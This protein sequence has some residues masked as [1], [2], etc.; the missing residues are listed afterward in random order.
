MYIKNVGIG[1][2]AGVLLALGFPSRLI[3]TGSVSFMLLGLLTFF[4]GLYQT[5]VSILGNQHDVV[6]DIKRCS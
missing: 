5:V 1:L 2:I 3:E 6:V 4:H